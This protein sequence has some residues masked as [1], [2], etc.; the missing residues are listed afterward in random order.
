MPKNK[1]SKVKN[2]YPIEKRFSLSG[3]EREK[4]QRLTRMLRDTDAMVESIALNL[5]KKLISVRDRLGVDEKVPENIDRNV[6]FDPDALE[7][8]VTDNLKDP[9]KKEEE[10]KL[11]KVV[12]EVEK[13]SVQEK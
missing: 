3:E 6:R 4:V 13:H 2:K 7:L 8:I 10:E 1:K 11:K 9:K 12:E 5:N